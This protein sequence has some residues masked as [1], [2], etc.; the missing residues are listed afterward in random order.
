MDENALRDLLL[1]E[2]AEFRRLS[3]EHKSLEGALARLRARGSADEASAREETEL[4]KRK[5]AVKDALYRILAEA[6]RTRTEGRP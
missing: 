3:E 6:R 4:K 1:R 2:D 5:L